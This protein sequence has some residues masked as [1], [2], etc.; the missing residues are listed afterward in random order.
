ML[1]QPR[2]L[3]AKFPTALVSGAASRLSFVEFGGRDE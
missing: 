2:S 3:M 1:K